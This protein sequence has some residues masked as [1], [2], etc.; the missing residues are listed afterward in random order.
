MESQNNR[1]KKDLKEILRLFREK[2][3]ITPFKNKNKE[4][5]ELNQIFNIIQKEIGKNTKLNLKEEMQEIKA[6]LKD[7]LEIE[8]DWLR[9]I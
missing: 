3:L 1:D 7:L 9:Y 2:V 8:R 5:K 6:T 4:N